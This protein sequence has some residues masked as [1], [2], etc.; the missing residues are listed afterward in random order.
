MKDYTIIYDISDIYKIYKARKASLEEQI[1]ILE[2]YKEKEFIET[3]ADKDDAIGS[4]ETV[5]DTNTYDLVFKSVSGSKELGRVSFQVFTAAEIELACVILPIPNEASNANIANKPA[6]SLPG[7][8]SLNA[9]LI[10]YIGPPSISPFS[11]LT[12]YFVASAHSANFVV[13]PNAAEIH[14][15]TNA[16]GPP[17]TIAV[18]TPTILPVPIVDA[19]AVISA[20]KGEI[21]PEPSAPFWRDSLLNSLFKNG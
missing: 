15:H 20:E 21:S 9:A 4:V 10:E 8:L 19:N 11:F 6:K 7:S 16:P 12:R 14:I 18:A 1:N 2:A 13:I 5:E 3:K 17:A